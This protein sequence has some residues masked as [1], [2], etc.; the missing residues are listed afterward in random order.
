V[1]F[2]LF[3]EPE[4]EPFCTMT[5][6]GTSCDDSCIGT[7]AWSQTSKAVTLSNPLTHSLMSRS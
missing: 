4:A 1:F 6:H 7:A 2:N 3:F 5:G